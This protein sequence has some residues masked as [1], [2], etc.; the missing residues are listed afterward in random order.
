MSSSTSCS[1][2]DAPAVTGC[3]VPSI[4][5]WSSKYCTSVSSNVSAG[6][7]SPTASG[8][9][10]STTSA[11]TTFVMDARGSGAV[12]PAAPSTPSYPTAPNALAPYGG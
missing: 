12:V 6:P 5:S 8:N 11:V 1:E 10:S 4:A 7:S 9:A 3:R 2:S